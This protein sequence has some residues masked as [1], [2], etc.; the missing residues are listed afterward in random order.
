MQQISRRIN[1]RRES[2]RE[3]VQNA[4]RHLPK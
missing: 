2:I 3:R 1:Q 4:I